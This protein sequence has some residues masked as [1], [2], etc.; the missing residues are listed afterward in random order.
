M[1]LL[2]IG[3]GNMGHTYALGIKNQFASARISIL[4]AYPPKIKELEEE[5]LFSIHSSPEKCIPQADVLMIAVK[6]QHSGDLFQSIKPFMND[7]HLVISIMAGVKISTIQNTLGVNAVV[8]AMPNLPAQVGKGMTA[9]C[10]SPDVTEEQIATVEEILGST[11]KCLR[12]STERDI[13]A[14]TGISGSG[15]AYVF[16]FMQSL[17]KAAIDFGFTPQESRELVTQTFS[18]AIEL[19]DQHNL[20]TEEWIAR[21]ASKGG[22]TRAALNSFEGDDLELSIIKGARAAFD[23][24]IE[25]GS[26]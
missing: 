7:E 22:T 16:Y 13:D 12:V 17:M 18:G 14:S 2:V 8:R 11:G 5:G 25:L 4:E 1:N 10:T 20:S 9:F 24:A 23:R 15:P 21:V 19:F 26:E 3:G 6:P